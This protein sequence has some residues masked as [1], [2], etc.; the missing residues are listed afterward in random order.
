MRIETDKVA[1]SEHCPRPDLS[2]LFSGFFEIAYR[3]DNGI[4]RGMGDVWLALSRFQFEERGYDADR[5]R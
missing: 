2:G 3:I 4:W 5:N 1:L